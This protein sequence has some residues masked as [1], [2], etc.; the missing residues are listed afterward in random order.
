MERSSG[1]LMAISSLPSKYGIGTLGQAAY[2]FTDF[3]VKAGQKYWQMLPLGPISY[4]DSP[5]QSFSSFA[6]NPYFI[7][8]DLLAGDGLLTQAEIDGY[9][10]GADPANV[11]YGKIYESRFK[12]LAIAKE[13]GYKRDK[14]EVD[15]F[16]EEKKWVCDYALF[17]ACKRHFGMTCWQTWPDEDIK[18]RKPEAIEKYRLDLADD[19]ELFIYIQYL[20]FKQWSKLK[21]YIH[22]AGIQ[23]IGDIPIYAALDSVDVWCEPWQFQLDEDLAPT[24]VAGCPPDAFSETGQLWGNPL[25]NWDFMKQDGFGWWIRR[26]DGVGQLYDKIRIDHFRGF[27]EYW[28]IPAGDKTAENGKWRPG[29]GLDLIN[30]LNWW[31]PNL[32]YI[33]EDL[34]FLTPSVLKLVRDSGWPG[35]KVLEF[36]FDSRE[37]SDYLPHKYTQNCICYTGTH[38]N[39]TLI[40]W[41]ETAAPEDVKLAEEYLNLTEEEGFLWGFIRGGMSSV[42]DLFIAPL[43]DYLE[44]G[45]EARMNQPAVPSGWWRWRALPEDIKGAKAEALAEKIKTFA[46]RYG[47]YTE[48]AEENKDKTTDEA[49]AREE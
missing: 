6:G 29:P 8:L 19:Y 40:Q 45:A 47:R 15:R 43:Q 42:A 16:C 9:D 22:A 44:L 5:Y 46:K 11:D 25:Y 38:D 23:I 3:L 30:V 20:F 13:R 21:D 35:M 33:A 4:G 48:P 12:I 37:A 34:G 36:A 10:W 49:E 17:M 18:R 39:E 7:D 24:Q 41:R 28:S 31:F 27:D 32:S 1:I 26:I 2:D 14:A